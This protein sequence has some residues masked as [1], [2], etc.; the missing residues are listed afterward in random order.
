[1]M[2]VFEYQGWFK[3]QDLK[4]K[5]LKMEQFMYGRYLSSLDVRLSE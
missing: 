4:Y 1:M 2:G 3:A 5:R